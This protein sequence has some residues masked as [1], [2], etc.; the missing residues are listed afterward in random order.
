M[1]FFETDHLVSDLKTRSVRGGV[2]AL[3]AQG[4]KLVL[5]LGS[6][7][8]LARL[9]SPRDYGV[10]GMAAVVTGFLGLF[11]DMG[12]SVA[13][14]Q[15]ERIT[16]SEVTALF[17]VNSAVGLGIALL[18]LALAPLVA[19]FFGEPRLAPVVAAL[20][21]AFLLGGAAVQHQA[22]LRRQMRFGRLAFLET[23]TMLV[24]TAAGIGSAA[25]GLRYWSLVVMQLAT[26]A[27]TLV[28]AMLLC[29]WLPGRPRR[30]A[31]V[32]ALV[33]FGA[34]LMGFSVVNYLGKSVDAALLGWRW[35][36]TPVGL[37]GNARRLMQL[38]LTQ[39]S[40]PITQVA[41]PALSRI[42]QDPERYRAA[43]LRLLEKL[44]LLAMPGIACLIAM[45]DWFVAVLLGPQWAESGR[46][47]AILGIAALVEPICSTTGWLLISQARAREMLFASACDAG[48]RFGL[49]ALALPWGATGVA[50]AVALRLA[51]SAPLSLLIT[52]RRG[53]VPARDMA[54]ALV[55][56]SAASAAAFG[57]AAVVRALLGPG[58]AF[59]G[60]FLG[61]GA[62]AAAALAVLFVTRSG[63]RALRDAF[64]SLADLRRPSPQ[65]P[66]PPREEDLA[67][68]G[69]VRE[70]RE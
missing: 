51:V 50:V 14:I 28:L 54:K 19:W 47:F 10:F 9:L 67:A 29:P 62:G 23:A 64:A 18:S 17:W 34:H 25:A 2:A 55:A 63:R 41:L 38:P 33:G 52:G 58:P 15:R 45:S 4:L 24:G 42:A 56:P 21:L 6:T 61:S 59:S 49:V 60:L 48:L 22:L 44:L 13:T 43:Y 12:L 68:V 70:S 11:Q 8:V 16:H 40:A 30:G 46:L 57:A 53:P 69:Q 65:P 31:D 37:F 66:S 32:K 3:G 20:A 7:V 1:R 27:S 35:G 5:Q 39:I 26:G 36:A